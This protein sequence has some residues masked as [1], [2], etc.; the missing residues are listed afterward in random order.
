MDIGR[1][2]GHQVDRAE[3]MSLMTSVGVSVGLRLAVNAL[4]K[5]VPGWGSAFGA[6]TSFASTFAIGEAANAWFKSGKEMSG[7][8]LQSVFQN[9]RLAGRAHYDEHKST[10]DGKRSMVSDTLNQLGDQLGTG[11]MSVTR[12]SDLL[13]AAYDTPPPQG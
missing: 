11:E 9:A 8:E 7:D 2:W 12:A 6:A 1:Y 10:I 4:A 5:L 3:A 13:D